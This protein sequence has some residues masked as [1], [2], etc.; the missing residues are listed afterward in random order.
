[1]HLKLFVYL[2]QSSRYY[3]PKTDGFY[4]DSKGSRGWRRRNPTHEK[5]L[6][7]DRVIFFAFEWQH[8][9]KNSASQEEFFTQ[10]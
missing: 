7:Q 8:F 1:M 2:I 9:W 6:L 4:Y 5:K 3:D 10:F